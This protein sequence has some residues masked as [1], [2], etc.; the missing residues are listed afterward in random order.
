LDPIRAFIAI[1]LPEDVRREL[2]RRIEHL[3]NG[4]PGLPVRWVR[5]GGIHLTLRFL[6]DTQPEQVSEMQQGLTELGAANP[7]FTLIIG[8]LGCFPNSRRPRVI[9]VGVE[10]KTGALDQLQRGVEG[11]CRKLGFP[12]D[13]RSFS[14]HLT[15][16]R[17]R[18]GGEARTGD[19]FGRFVEADQGDMLG[20]VLVEEMVL[21]Q[22]ELK[23]DGAVYRRLATARLGTKQ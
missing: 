12:P 3:Q 23:P 11:L 13:R 8:G 2:G 21:F 20:Q 19:E 5:P 9:W 10:E 16:G 14:A 15:L 6:G 1:D 18:Q 7:G 4:M 17:V 22:S